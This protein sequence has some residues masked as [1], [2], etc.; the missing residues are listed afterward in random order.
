MTIIKGYELKIR[1]K[2]T[3][4]T[5]IQCQ[6]RTNDLQS[7]TQEI[8]PKDWATW[9]SQKHWWTLRYVNTNNINKHLRHTK[10]IGV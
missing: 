8:K 2:G 7:T 1:Y 6:N 3:D 10:Q 4:I 5:N 9:N